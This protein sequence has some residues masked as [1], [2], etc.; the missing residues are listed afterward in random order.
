MRKQKSKEYLTVIYMLEMKGPVRRAYIAKEMMLSRPAVSAAVRELVAEGL[1][2]EDQEH[3]IRLT[4]QGQRMAKESICE[5][6]NRGRDLQTIAAQLQ[7][8][9]QFDNLRQKQQTERILWHLKQD[10][11]EAIPEAILILSG[12]Y[13]C[14]RVVDVGQFLNC[15]SAAVQKKLTRMNHYDLVRQGEEG[16]LKLTETGTELARM[17]YEQHEQ[18]RNA[19]LQTGMDLFEAEREVLLKSL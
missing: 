10:R 6:V 14:V 17:L 3:L 11:S 15:G 1:L 18:E 13:Y 8:E 12:R 9:N 16:V 2:T 4:E 7:E 5:T 19:M